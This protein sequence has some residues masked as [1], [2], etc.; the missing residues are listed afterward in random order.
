MAPVRIMPKSGRLVEFVPRGRHAGKMPM[1]SWVEIL[2]KQSAVDPLILRALQ[3]YILPFEYSGIRYLGANDPA[4]G[5]YAAYREFTVP[6][7]TDGRFFV[8]AQPKLGARDSVQD[9]QLLIAKS[10]AHA[11]D[12]GLWSEEDNYVTIEIS[13]EARV[14]PNYRSIVSGVP[15][16]RSTY[17]Q[18]LS[19]AVAVPSIAWSDSNWSPND[20]N[21]SVS[22]I[23]N[24]FRLTFPRG[25]ASRQSLDINFAVP[26]GAAVTTGAL[27]TVTPS[28]DVTVNSVFTTGVPTTTTSTAAFSL[29]ANNIEVT[30]PP[31]GGTVDFVFPAP[32]N[33]IGVLAVR[34]ESRPTLTAS[35]DDGNFTAVQAVAMALWAQFSG[36]TLENG[37]RIAGAQTP[38]EFINS[39]TLT[40]N[41][42]KAWVPQSYGSYVNNQP[43]IE[44]K[45]Y[46]NGRAEHGFYGWWLPDRPEDK[47]LRAPSS[48]NAIDGP[49]LVF[50]GQMAS[51]TT[52]QMTAY[53][54]LHYQFQTDNT[55]L[56]VASVGKRYQ[57]IVIL[58]ANLAI[59]LGIL[60]CGANDFHT[61]FKTA[62]E[63]IGMWAADI[64]GAFG[65]IGNIVAQR[66]MEN[67]R[68][69]IGYSTKD[70]VRI[71]A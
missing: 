41:S 33:A 49:C 4:V 66:F 61:W 19:P 32:T 20:F 68:P 44:G 30:L 63:N 18:T 28:S 45:N 52:G 54:T 15:A 57:D 9:Y 37:G 16:G 5:T 58:V 8:M 29:Y 2:R 3:Q 40:D 17:N 70:G 22:A 25:T 39:H 65:Q 64:A 31:G 53:W 23:A 69:A 24:G 56:P 42:T 21:L 67:M 14:D 38:P 43:G 27:P 59:E 55:L 36:N 6:L 47:E 12:D 51:V 11:W 48:L 1:S 71:S 35:I 26:S 10:D 62:L 50:S 13:P 60:R 46:P 34:I 7:S